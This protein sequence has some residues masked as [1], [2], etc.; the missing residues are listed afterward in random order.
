VIAVEEHSVIGGLGSI[1]AELVAERGG[2]RLRRIGIE[3]RFG[4]SA[5]NDALLEAFGLSVDRVAERVRAFAD[6]TP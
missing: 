4:E 2:P 1:V 5:P 3:D 6:L